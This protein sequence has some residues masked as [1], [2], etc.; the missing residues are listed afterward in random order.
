MILQAL[1]TA[2]HGLSGSPE[3]ISTEALDAACD[4]VLDARQEGIAFIT[5]ESVDVVSDETL[6]VLAVLAGEGVYDLEFT[7]RA[8]VLVTDLERRISYV[9]RWTEWKGMPLGPLPPPEVS[10]GTPQPFI[11]F[12]GRSDVRERLAQLPWIPSALAVQL[13]VQGWQSQPSS[14]RLSGNP[15]LNDPKVVEFLRD[16][17]VDAPR[18]E[19]DSAPGL[20][21]TGG[22][23]E[24]TTAPPALPEDGV[25]A[26]LSPVAFASKE[27]SILL[28]FAF[29]LPLLPFETR[30]FSSS[31]PLDAAGRMLAAKVALSIAVTGETLVEPVVLRIVVPVYVVDEQ[32]GVPTRGRAQGILN[33]ATLPRMPKAQGRYWARVVAGPA[34][35]G[36]LPLT[37]VPEN[38][39]VVRV[40]DEG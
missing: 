36:A 24:G 38:L 13:L 12:R 14:V 1:P 37:L 22:G 6:P 39:R 32:S 29:N 9:A 16:R 21:V 27:A 26:T 23:S 8:N 4:R 31:E 30:R 40:R 18:V 33:L 17:A 25:V 10:P 7:E 3:R 19:A 5:P 15:F 20:W 2:A 34:Q 28:G 11:V 35:T